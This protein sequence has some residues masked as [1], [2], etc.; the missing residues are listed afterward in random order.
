MHEGD[1]S[2]F[3]DRCPY[4]FGRRSTSPTYG[5]RL[6]STVIHRAR[7][8]IHTHHPQASTEVEALFHVKQ[9]LLWTTA[10]DNVSYRS[11]TSADPCRPSKWRAGEPALM[12]SALMGPRRYLRPR[13]DACAG[14]RLSRPEAGTVV[15]S[16]A[17]GSSVIATVERPGLPSAH[18]VN[19]PSLALTTALTPDDGWSGVRGYPAGVGSSAPPSWSAQQPRLLRHLTGYRASCLSNAG[20]YRRRFT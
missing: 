17:P 9:R 18:L 15:R 14:R 3:R 16:A 10:V 12:G 20:G 13:A 7:R 11:S 8:V 2:R 6:A 1:P 19:M 4:S 5:S